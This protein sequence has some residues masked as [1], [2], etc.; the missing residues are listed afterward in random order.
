MVGESSEVVLLTIAGV[1]LVG[2]ACVAVLMFSALREGPGDPPWQTGNDSDDGRGNKPQRPRTPSDRPR[3]GIP[4][5]DAEQSRIRLRD[6]RTLAD[7][8]P[9]RTR[10]PAREPVTVP[11]RTHH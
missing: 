6:H 7:R 11:A 8:I 5:P 1:H 4:L 9:A 2:L 3:G 10:R